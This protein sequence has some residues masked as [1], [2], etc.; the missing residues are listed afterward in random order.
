MLEINKHALF[1]V[2][3]R[4]FAFE[5]VLINSH[6]KKTNLSNKYPWGPQGR[7][8]KQILTLGT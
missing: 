4:E 2:Q 3:V 5:K 8:V 1:E 6:V 7:I